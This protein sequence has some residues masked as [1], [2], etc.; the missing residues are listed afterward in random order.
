MTARQ[1]VTHPSG[2]PGIR[3]V[4]R[5][6]H[7]EVGDPLLDVNARLQP[8]VPCPV[9]PPSVTRTSR[10][11]HGLEASVVGCFGPTTPK[12]A[13]RLADASVDHT[14]KRKATVRCFG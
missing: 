8:V 9:K 7:R 11:C 2:V 13:A 5:I 3:T 10:P 12:R 1:P 6:A 4:A 14:D